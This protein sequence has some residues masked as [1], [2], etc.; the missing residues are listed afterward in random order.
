MKKTALKILCGL[1]CCIMAFP[2]FTGCSKSKKDSVVI[3]TEELSGLFNPFYATSGTDMDVVGMTQISMLSTDASGAPT[4]GIDE[5]T[6]VLDFN[7]GIYNEDKDET[8][9]TFVI[10][11][12]LKFSD[13]KHPLTMNDIMFNIYEYLDPVYTGSSTMYSIDIKGLSE[14]RMQSSQDIDISDSAST[15][16]WYR[17]YELVK[18]YEDNGRLAADSSSFKMTEAQMTAAINAHD[19]SDTYKDAIA[20]EAKQA[21]M[22]DADYRAQL[23]ADYKHALETFKEELEADF[24]EAKESFDLTTEPYKEHASKLSNDIFKFFLYEGYIEPKYA[25]LPNSSRD[26]KTKIIEF[27]N[28]GIVNSYKTEAEAINR[29]YSDNVETGLNTILTQWGTAGT[30]LTEYT[31]AAID[32]ALHNQMT[33]NALTFPNIEGIV[34]V[35]H[36]NNSSNTVRRNQVTVNGNTYAVA[37][38][39]NPDGTPAN[40]NEY[41]VLEITVEGRDPKAIYNFGFAVA[42]AYYYSADEN[43]PN[44]REIDICNDKFGV[45]WASSDFQSKTIQSQLHVEVPVGAGPYVAT[46]A[47]NKNNPGGDEFWSS[48]AVYFKA[49][50]NFMFPVKAKKLRMQVVSA[51]NA[52]DKLEKGEVDYITPQFTK[53]NSERLT[54]MQKK[55]FTQLNSWQLG[56]GYIGINAGKV[57]NINIRRAIM[58]AM[59]TSLSLEFYQSGT[60]KTIDWPMSM[61]SWAYPFADDGTTSKPNQWDYTRWT[62]TD[63]ENFPDAKEK[64]QYYMT[65]AGVTNPAG[66]SRLDVTFTIAGA[67]ITEHPTYAVFKQAAD[68][69]NSMGWDVDVKADSQALTKLSTGSLEVWAAAWG[70]TIDPDMYQVYHKDSTATSVYAW[71]YR[72]IKLNQSSYPEENRIITELSDLID[73]GREYMEREERKPIYESAMNLVIELAVELP[74]YQRKTLYAYNNKTIKG[75]PAQDKVDS[76]NSPLSKIWEIELV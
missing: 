73:Q 25:Q 65:Q 29:V 26:D 10:K 56:Y 19:V 48:G 64:I 66:D 23:L 4:A 75:L 68:I 15:T 55:G 72:E 6:V 61:E 70:S 50:E 62:D 60:C 12:G 57:E 37:H 20:T 74:V 46:D 58:S 49:N 36:M 1:L 42:P 30:L 41:D 11:N 27:K 7:Q 69:L 43:Y 53:A 67:S 34:S 14:Y 51:S 52:I 39:H 38:D 33:G 71:G 54:A 44:G 2:V 22:S 8:V 24:K 40:A 18:L 47:N 45:E 32:V 16:A 59:Q 31:A 76:Y 5:P 63:T 28:E 17:I 9:Y 3:M 13:G 21:T 35:G